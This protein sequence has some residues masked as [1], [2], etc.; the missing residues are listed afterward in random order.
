LI[1]C[2]TGKGKIMFLC[3]I[4]DELEKSKVITV[5]YF[6]CQAT[7]SRINNAT[8]VLRGLV[9]VSR[10]VEIF[11]DQKVSELS[12]TGQS[13]V[14]QKDI[15]YEMHR[16]A[17]ARFL[18]VALVFQTLERE[19]VESRE[20]NCVELYYNNELSARNKLIDRVS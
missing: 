7:D 5:S 2:Y 6:F 11:V 4:I 1:Q 18:W 19:K 3:D 16:K 17:N 14:L 12:S 10:A 15:R 13:G 9:H 8:A 20:C